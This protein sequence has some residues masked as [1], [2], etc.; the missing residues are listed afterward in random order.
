M[1][2]ACVG[3]CGVDI[4]Q[5]SGETRVGGITAN[6]ARHARATFEPEDDIYVVSC[7][8]DD[9]AAGLVLDAFVDSGINCHISRMPGKT[10]VQYIE[11]KPDGERH[12]VHY[13]P[14]VLAEFRFSEAQRN[15]IAS[16]DI[17]VAPVYLQIVGLFDAMMSIPTRGTVAIDFADF[18]E[19]PDFD[20]LHSHIDRIDIGF[21]GLTSDDTAAIREIARLAADHHKLFVVTLGA[22]GSIVFSADTRFEGVALPV[23]QV[24]DTTGAGDAFATAFLAGYCRNG[25]IDAAIAKGSALAASV[26]EHLGSYGAG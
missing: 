8:G 9:R 18:L 13:E 25:D 21:F 6:V 23:S 16:A 12:F 17:V 2:I 15:V 14:G 26:V 20:L 11:I 24:V 22:D 4:Y 3:D 5:P 1:E 10:P 7:V 19:H